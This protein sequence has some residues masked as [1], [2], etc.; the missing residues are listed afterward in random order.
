VGCEELQPGRGLL[1]GLAGIAV[2]SVAW[3]DRDSNLMWGWAGW[4]CSVFCVMGWQELQS[5]MWRGLGYAAVWSWSVALA[6]RDC[7]WSVAWAGK[8]CS[9]ACAVGWEGLQLVLYIMPLY[10]S[11][12]SI[13]EFLVSINVKI[14]I[15]YGGAAYL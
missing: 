8:D 15:Y 2:W 9:L 14:N 11:A 6:G 12:R 3:A 4:D 10:F 1:R 7:V 13:F 5:G